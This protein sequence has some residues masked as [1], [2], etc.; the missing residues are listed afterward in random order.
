MS[1]PG[2]IPKTTKEL[3]ELI[4]NKWILGIE[5]SHSISI[6]TSILTENETL[7][8]ARSGTQL[9]IPL[10]IDT[11]TTVTTVI[12]FYERIIKNL[13]KEMS[14][15]IWTLSN[16]CQFLDFAKC[17][18]GCVIVEGGKRF[19][20]VWKERIGYCTSK[21]AIE[22]FLGFE[23]YQPNKTKSPPLITNVEEGILEIAQIYEF[24]LNPPDKKLNSFNQK[25]ITQL[26]EDLRIGL[27]QFFMSIDVFDSKVL[28]GLAEHF[29]L[30]DFFHL[31]N[32]SE[33]QKLA[34]Q[35]GSSVSKFWKSKPVNPISKIFANMHKD[36]SES[37]TIF[38]KNVN[39]RIQSQSQQQKPEKLGLSLTFLPLLYFCSILSSSYLVI[40][41]SLL[42]HE[43]EMDVISL[44]KQK[45]EREIINLVFEKLRLWVTQDAKQSP[46]PFSVD[47]AIILRNLQKVDFWNAAS[48]QIINFPIRKTVEFPRFN[49]VNVLIPYFSYILISDKPAMSHLKEFLFN[50]LNS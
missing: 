16:K 33:S 7:K 19:F 3:F 20:E 41:W 44:V 27:P 14:L 1:L 46:A 49:L 10:I 34:A 22:S 48:T 43:K 28:L 35:S 18:D 24:E 23:R 25:L 29:V 2:G 12:E 39:L 6:L 47:L 42:R 45:N 17:Q 9:Y 36:V 15:L 21:L 40:L 11:P 4:V 26:F 37:F 38:E 50:R 32:R 8:A 13:V 30:L 31:L 5:F